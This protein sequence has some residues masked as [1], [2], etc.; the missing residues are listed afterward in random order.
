MSDGWILPERERVPS[1]HR[2]FERRAP[3]YPERMQPKLLIYHYAVDGDQS[4]DDD[5]DHNFMLRVRSDDCMDVA[6]GFQKPRR[7][8]STHFIVGR[9]G[10]KAQCVS[11]EDGCWGAG[12]SGLSRFPDEPPA[13]IET[14]PFRARYVN[15]IS[16]QI[17]MCN[18]GWA[19][20]AFDVPQHM[21]IKAKH[22][23]QRTEREWEMYTDYQYGT[24]KLL[25]AL[26]KMAY[27]SVIW[28]CGHEDVTNR[29]TMR[30]VGGKTDPGP[31]WEWER[32]ELEAHGI[33]RV[34]YDFDLRSFVIVSE[35]DTQP[36]S[37]T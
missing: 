1:P 31:A 22:P 14:I 33:Q 17:E 36:I 15:L 9:D 7:R 20:D 27:P 5:L 35:E 28:A 37:V 8:A 23:A 24:T 13:K 34:R 32:L 18:V 25:T 10:S 12:D 6:R 19:V 21:R 3:G 2:Y 4:A 26:V 11:L 30:K 29:H 16:V